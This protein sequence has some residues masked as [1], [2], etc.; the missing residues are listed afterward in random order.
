MTKSLRLL[1]VA[2]LA[3]AVLT[4]AQGCFGKPP[5]GPN[6]A[7]D[8]FSPGPQIPEEL[9]D[10]LENSKRIFAG[11][12]RNHGD[13]TYLLA[14]WGQKPTAGYVV[15]IVSLGIQNNEVIV[16][17]RFTEPVPGHAVAEVI[18]YPYDLVEVP[19][20]TVPARFV[21]EGG[22]PSCIP[23]VVGTDVVEPI[24][25]ETQWIKLFSPSPGQEIRD[26]L[27]VRGIANVFEG[28][29]NFRLR[30]DNAT[31]RE[32]FATGAMGDWGYFTASVPLNH[33]EPGPVQLEVFTYSAEDGS[34]ENHMTIPLTIKR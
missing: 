19:R 10:W 23:G 12:T 21:A 9:R 7:Q 28:T 26:T 4:C 30:R 29:V 11:Q 8:G 34:I 27:E 15:K 33:V 3:L 2:L 20:L 17:C 22:K 14:T 32:G 16:T 6:N 1:L 18:T 13:R 24:V 25:S 31:L 5:S